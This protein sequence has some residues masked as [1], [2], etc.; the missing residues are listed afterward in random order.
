[1]D[2][3]VCEGSTFQEPNEEILFEQALIESARNEVIQISMALIESA[4]NVALQILMVQIWSAPS[5]ATQCEPV[6]NEVLRNESVQT[7]VLLSVAVLTLG[8]RNGAFQSVVAAHSYP[9]VKVL[10]APL[11][12]VHYAPVRFWLAHFLAG[13]FAEARSVLVVLI[14]AV[15]PH[16]SPELTHCE[17]EV[18]GKLEKMSHFSAVQ[19]GPVLP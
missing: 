14:V 17:L 7:V 10:L 9:D 18:A 5:V 16:S 12:V 6:P 15:A 4:Q 8:L 3:L 1:L 19:A 2:C 13:R 11:H